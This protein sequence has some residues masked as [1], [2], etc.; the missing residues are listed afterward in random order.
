MPEIY[1]DESYKK[2]GTAS[3]ENF[4]SRRRRR[5]SAE[6]ASNNKNSWM[7]L[8][9][10]EPIH[11]I[12]DE[13]RETPSR[14]IVKRKNIASA[15]LGGHDFSFDTQ[16]KQTSPSRRRHQS[17]KKRTRKDNEREFSKKDADDASPGNRT[18]GKQRPRVSL[19]PTA[20]Q[21]QQEL[22][23][24]Q[25]RRDKHGIDE[26]NSIANASSLDS[27]LL[28]VDFILES[29]G[30]IHEQLTKLE[31]QPNCERKKELLFAKESFYVLLDRHDSE[32]QAFL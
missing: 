22:R 8:V 7:A 13:I 14:K 27:T 31:E 10:Q 11:V 4:A 6:D 17:A 29:I 12:K 16:A 5:A 9:T 21:T 30:R 2:R 3:R 28:S 18:G 15:F 24:D 26:Q 19:S 32:D 20:Q 23:N 1:F 25:G